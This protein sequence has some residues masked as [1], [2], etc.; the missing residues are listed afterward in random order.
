VTAFE[1]SPEAIEAG[2]EFV[3][4]V[5]AGGVHRPIV[6]TDVEAILARAVEVQPVVAVPLCPTCKGERVEM[7]GA[8]DPDCDPSHPCSGC[9]GS[10]YDALIPASEIRRWAEEWRQAA[11]RDRLAVLASLDVLLDERR[12]S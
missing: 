10:G 1:W 2:H 7:R 11:P 6:L 3:R 8:P 12:S 4:E 5:R 9:G